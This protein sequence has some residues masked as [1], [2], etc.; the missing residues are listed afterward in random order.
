MNNESL[1][2]FYRHLST[3]DK[4]AFRL[5]LTPSFGMD[6]KSFEAALDGP[7]NYLYWTPRMQG[8]TK[9][10]MHALRKNREKYIVATGPTT[11]FWGGNI[12]AF[13]EKT[14]R[15]LDTNYLDVLQIHW[16]GKMS[17]YTKGTVE[18]LVKLRDEGKVRAIGCSIHDRERAGRLVAD[19]PLDLFM[20]RY[21]AAHPGA[22]ADIFPQVHH[23]QPSMIAYTATRWR[24]LLNRPK[25]WEGEV[26]TAGDCY[27]FCLTN[28]GVDVVL[29][30][31]K[32]MAQFEENLEAI[33]LGPL[34]NE[35]LN[36][37]RDFGKV[38]RA[39]SRLF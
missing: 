8:T 12:R 6:G 15:Q 3:I 39:Q 7:T 5:G 19:S 37:M 1:D 38:V 25:H 22:E 29:H 31:P 14:L 35:E 13:T 33:K 26:P 16:L 21:N 20:I 17:A 18:T 32:N 27:R 23:R 4:T 30:G 24:K 2:F 28:E 36:W 34:S 10:L 11:A 9:P